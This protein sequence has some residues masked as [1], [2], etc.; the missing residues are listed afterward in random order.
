MILA[1]GTG[2]DGPRRIRLTPSAPASPSIGTSRFRRIDPSQ[3]NFAPNNAG[4]PTI[5]DRP[6][7][8]PTP[9]P[10]AAVLRNVQEV[11][12]PPPPVFSGF[13]GFTGFPAPAPAP[14]QAPNLPNL[15]PPIKQ[16][17]RYFGFGPGSPVADA[18]SQTLFGRGDVKNEGR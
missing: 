6:P 4:L 7:P 9:G 11:P 3:V 15:G 5:P 8:P 12:A 18:V 17:L 1:T 16:A 2:Q 13:P 10:V 14:V